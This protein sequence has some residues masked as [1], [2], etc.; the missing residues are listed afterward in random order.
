MRNFQYQHAARVVCFPIAT[1]PFVHVSAA[2]TTH[3]PTNSNLSTVTSQTSPLHA[4][5]NHIYVLIFRQFLNVLCFSFNDSIIYFYS[6]C[7]YIYFFVCVATRWRGWLRN[8]AAS[9]KVAGSIPDG[10]IRI[11]HGHN[12]FD[13]TMALGL[14]QPLAE[15]ITGNI[16]WGVKAAGA[17]C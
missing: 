12:P 14:T 1:C 3:I 8:C 2:A 10:V 5:A 11:F 16:S 13:R 15:M 9:Q 4:T 17:W 7:S 6:H